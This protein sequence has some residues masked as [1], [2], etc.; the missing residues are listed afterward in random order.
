LERMSQEQVA[1]LVDVEAV[2]RPNI[3]QQGLGQRRRVMLERGGHRK[4]PGPP[5]ELLTRLEPPSKGAVYGV[6]GIAQFGQPL[7]ELAVLASVH[8]LLTD[9]PSY[10][11]LQFRVRDLFAVTADRSHEEVLAF[12]EQGGED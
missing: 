2:L 11:F 5:R 1:D 6:G 7:V 9:E 3:G 8:R 4:A 12:G 10:L